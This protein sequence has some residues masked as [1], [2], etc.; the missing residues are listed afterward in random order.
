MELIG[1]E[2]CATASFVKQSDINYLTMGELREWRY[3]FIHS[4]TSA[5][6]RDERSALRPCRFT[7][8][9]RA[10]GTHWIG[11]IQLS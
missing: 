6:D 10:P 11:G 8:K 5:L 9:E 2:Y 7:A 4:F 1:S 3:S